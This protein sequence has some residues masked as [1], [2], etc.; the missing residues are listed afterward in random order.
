VLAWTGFH[1]SA[2]EGRISFA[3]QEGTWFWSTGYAWGTCT[4]ARA[5]GG[6]AVT[7]DVRYGKLSLRYIELAH[8]G[9]VDLGAVRTLEAGQRMTWQVGPVPG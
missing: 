5:N 9:T 3:P 7:L 4:Q 6:H 1:Y 2:V 8:T